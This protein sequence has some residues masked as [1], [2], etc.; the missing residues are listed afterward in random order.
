MCC[1]FAALTGCASTNRKMSG[2]SLDENNPERDEALSAT[3]LS[4]PVIP[5]ERAFLKLDF[6]TN[7]AVALEEWRHFDTNTGPK[8]NF[9]TFDENHEGQVNVTEFLTQAP[10]YPKL[11]SAFGNAEQINNNDFSWDG[12]E[13]H[14]QGLRLFSIRF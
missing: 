4:Q 8:E 1:A 6:E 14:P 2:S 10:K 9:G 3:G 7:G 5:D 13:F 11:Y 12:Q